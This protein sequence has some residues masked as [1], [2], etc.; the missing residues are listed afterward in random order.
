M[1]FR[2][3]SLTGRYTMF[4]YT[5]ATITFLL[6]APSYSDNAEWSYKG[7]N[8]PENWVND[9]P[10]CGMQNQSPIDIV[11]NETVPMTLGELSFDGCSRAELTDGG[12]NAS[13]YNDGHTI[14]VRNDGASC[15]ISG[16]HLPGNFKVDHFHLHWGSDSSTGSEHKMDGQVMSAE[17]HFVARNTDPT[18]ENRAAGFAVFIEI[19]QER[20]E[21]YDTFL[22]YVHQAGYKDDL[23]SLSHPIPLMELLPDNILSYYRYNGSKTSPNC[24]SPIIWTVFPEHVQI[25]E[26]QIQKLRV[27]NTTAAGM[28]QAEKMVDNYRPPQPIGSRMVYRNEG[29]DDVSLA[30]MSFVSVELVLGYFVLLAI[31]VTYI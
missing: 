19:G 20:N 17:L 11:D 23:A 30:S 21:V 12:Y 25:S 28:N 24:F 26:T 27:I 7:V 8:G 13:I 22:D 29:G 4:L 1:R 3:N 5:L 15:V 16:G 2:L 18:N 14:M 10:M 31:S 6:V 9:Y